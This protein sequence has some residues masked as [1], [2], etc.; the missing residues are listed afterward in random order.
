MKPGNIA[1]QLLLGRSHAKCKEQQL[2]A[3]TTSSNV[4]GMLA[5]QAARNNPEAVTPSGRWIN[6]VTA[7]TAGFRALNRCA[8]AT[9]M[10][11]LEALQHVTDS[12]DKHRAARA[13]EEYKKVQ[14]Y[15]ENVKVFEQKQQEFFEPWLLQVMPRLLTIPTRVI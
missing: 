15:L 4:I 6:P 8:R 13:A 14:N 2:L 7:A 12:Q 5:A 3:I 10:T 11:T 1:Q 9:L